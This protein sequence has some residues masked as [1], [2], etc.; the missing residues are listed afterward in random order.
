M[1]IYIYVY[2]YICIYIYVYDFPGSH[3]WLPEGIC[4]VPIH[5]LIIWWSYWFLGTNSPGWGQVGFG[6][7]RCPI[8]WLVY[9][10]KW[11]VH[12][13]SRWP[14]LK[15]DLWI[16]MAR[17]MN[18]LTYEMKWRK[19]RLISH[20]YVHTFVLANICSNWFQAQLGGHGRSMLLCWKMVWHP[21]SL[22]GTISIIIHLLWIFN[23]PVIHIRSIF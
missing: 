3:V 23:F 8:H 20:A 4:Y 18:A 12:Q 16:N 7:W 11:C 6:N 9:T 15:F 13:I 10:N 17:P 14:M 21:S 1:Y 22:Q 2:I 5:P 19:N